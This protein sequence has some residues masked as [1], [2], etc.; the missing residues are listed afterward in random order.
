VHPLERG[1]L[2]EQTI[3]ARDV[4]WRLGCER[5]MHEKAK[6]AEPVVDRDDHGALLRQTSAVVTLLS[7]EPGEESAAMDPHHHR[8]WA[9]SLE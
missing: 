4:M 7:A 9:T 2:V 6:H 8:P 5:G 3:V 1:H